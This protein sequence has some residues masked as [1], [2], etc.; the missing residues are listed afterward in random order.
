[1][2]TPATTLLDSLGIAWIGHQYEHDSQE[3]DF[4]KEAAFKLNL[5]PAQVFKTLIVRAD[6]GFAVAVIPVNAMLD[7]KAAAAA[8]GGKKADMAQVADAERITGYVHGGISPLGQRKKL[9]TVIDESAMDFPAIFVSGGRRGF[10]VEIAPADLLR[11]CDGS[12]A[13]LR[14]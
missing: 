8:V 11:A 9:P 10:D 6:I 14:R 5:D 3:R 13:A 4:G 12:L 7:L 1:M 2:Q